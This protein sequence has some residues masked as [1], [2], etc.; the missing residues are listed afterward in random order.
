MSGQTRSSSVKSRI[1]L[2]CG[3]P[4]I[5]MLILSALLLTDSIREASTMSSLARLTSMAPTISGLVHELQRERG[6]SGGFIGAGGKGDFVANLAAQHKDTDERLARY[7]EVMGSFDPSSYGEEVVT[8]H[9]NSFERLRGLSEMRANVTGLKVTAAQST[10]YYTQTINEIL[11]IVTVMTEV[12]S[13]DGLLST[14][15]SYNGLLLAKERAGLE[16]A[17]GAGAFA[18]GKF[19]ATSLTNFMTLRGQQDAFRAPNR[20][21]SGRSAS[22]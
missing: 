2:A 5:G 7:N 15:Q 18:Q 10:A 20:T 19:D 6:L 11:G 1:M 3:L 13:S 12:V 17:T 4:L 8:R 14:L 21:I 22:R 16:R 9:R